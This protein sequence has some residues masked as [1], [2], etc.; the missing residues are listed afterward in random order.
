MEK[1]RKD[2]EPCRINESLKS[3]CYKD[4]VP[5]KIRMGGWNRL[6]FEE[7]MDEK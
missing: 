6:I 2:N 4:C 5:R 7:I 3:L 1:H